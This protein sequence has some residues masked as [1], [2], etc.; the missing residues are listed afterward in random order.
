MTTI[1]GILKLE[2]VNPENQVIYFYYRNEKLLQEASLE[3]SNRFKKLLL[4]DYAINVSTNELIKNQLPLNEII[5]SFLLNQVNNMNKITAKEARGIMSA[6]YDSLLDDVYRKI[7]KAAE[8]HENQIILNEGFWCEYTK[9]WLEVR[10]ILDKDG[11][12]MIYFYRESN[13]A[14][15]AHTSIRW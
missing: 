2:A 7:R 13:L 14:L 8:Q 15:I 3:T 12:N 6:N 1:K 5:E 4:A 11:F 9:E 10:E